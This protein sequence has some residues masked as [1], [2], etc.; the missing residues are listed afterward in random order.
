VGPAVARC[1]APGSQAAMEDPDQPVRQPAQ[2]V[3]VLE[4]A[5]DGPSGRL[6]EWGPHESVADL[7]RAPGEH[8]CGLGRSRGNRY[9]LPG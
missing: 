5:I 1:R 6:D 9:R 7:R 4:P 2:C 8:G 3:V